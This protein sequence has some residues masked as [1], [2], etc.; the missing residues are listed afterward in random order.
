MWARVKHVRK[1]KGAALGQVLVDQVEESLLVDMDPS[2]EKRL[3][4]KA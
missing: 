4:I 2:L 3:R 1:I